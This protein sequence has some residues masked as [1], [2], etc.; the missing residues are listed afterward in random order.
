MLRRYASTAK[1]DAFTT[2]SSMAASRSRNDGTIANT[3]PATATSGCRRASDA[4]GALTAAGGAVEAGAADGDA[5]AVASVGT[6]L[7]VGDGPE[8]AVG[9]HAERRMTIARI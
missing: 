7:A 4:G 2:V 3:P 8:V 9:A 6:A 5:V 1:R